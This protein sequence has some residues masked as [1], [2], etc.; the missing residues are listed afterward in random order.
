MSFINR[1][2]RRKKMKY[3][4]ILFD[5]DGTLTDPKVG[6]TK[7]VQYALKKFNIKADNLDELISFIGPPLADSFME[8]YG[9][10]EEQAKK[11][12]DYYREY[13][14]EQGIFEN[15]IFDGIKELLGNLNSQE[16][17]LILAT[18]KPTIFAKKILEHFG[19]YKYFDFI[20]G[21]NLDGTRSDKTE[22]IGYILQ[23]MNLNKEETVMI[24]DRK[25]DIIGASN[26]QIAS[27]AVGYG[28]GSE[29]E[30]REFGPTH[31]VTTVEEL[32]MIFQ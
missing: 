4:N 20:C 14:R 27:I 32:K 18:S 11:A 28:Y 22:I 6:I 25:F 13:F 12:I 3:K 16:R 2:Y 8:F 26:N 30:L 5:L 10:S 29:E 21:S 24:G 15:Q 23:E 7:S 9:F 17:T 31:F 1:R 19:I